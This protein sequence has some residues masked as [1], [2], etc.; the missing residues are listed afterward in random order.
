MSNTTSNLPQEILEEFTKRDLT[1]RQKSFL[2]YLF[3]PEDNPKGDFR[4]AM[5]LAGYSK[6]TPLTDVLTPLREE[7][8]TLSKSFMALNSPSAIMQVLNVFNDPSRPGTSNILKAAEM[9]L[10]RGG[11]VKGSE[12]I[13]KK[14]V[15]NIFIL[16]EKTKTIDLTAEEYTDE[17]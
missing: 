1:P 16:P 8:V 10:D 9:V 17:E 15:K 13:E 5:D 7:I 11:V 3:S 4:R 6:K 2:F 12:T 14:E